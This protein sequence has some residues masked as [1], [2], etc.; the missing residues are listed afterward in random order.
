MT[1]CDLDRDSYLDP[2]NQLIIGRAAMAWFWDHD[3]P[4]PSV[5]ST[6]GRLAA[7]RP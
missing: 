4:D 5:R 3:A 7:A 2:S 6:P 1:D